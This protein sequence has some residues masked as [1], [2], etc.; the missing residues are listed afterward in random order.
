MN[1]HEIL[2]PDA[3]SGVVTVLDLVAATKG[4]T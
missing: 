4:Q 2:F 3:D 1:M